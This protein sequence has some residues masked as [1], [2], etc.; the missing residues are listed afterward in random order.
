M[1]TA[2]GCKH[3]GEDAMG[4]IV[5]VQR[6]DCPFVD[7][8][9]SAVAAGAVAVII[10]NT[11][12]RDT[13]ML[14][15]DLGA[16]YL[17]IPVV[18]VGM[19]DGA[20]LLQGESV[21]NMSAY[22]AS[23]IRDNECF[24]S[25]AAGRC[26]DW[27]GYG[28]SDA[29]LT[30]FGVGPYEADELRLA[31]PEACNT[32][33]PH[34][35]RCSD[36]SDYTI[37][38]LSQGMLQDCAA[39]K[40]RKLCSQDA[41]RKMC[42]RTCGTCEIEVKCNA[43]NISPSD[44][45]FATQ[46]SASDIACFLKASFSHTSASCQDA[47]NAA[48]EQR[49]NGMFNTCADIKPAGMCDRAVSLCPVTCMACPPSGKVQLTIPS[50]IKEIPLQSD[51]IVREDV[52]LVIT[53][54]AQADMSRPIF[55]M[56]NFSIRVLHGGSLHLNEV[57]VS[58]YT[59]TQSAIVLGEE[60][61]AYR[62]PGNRLPDPTWA[63]NDPR[64]QNL[65]EADLQTLLETHSQPS[66]RYD[67]PLDRPRGIFQNCAFKNM[68]KKSIRHTLLASN[69][70]SGLGFFTPDQVQLFSNSWSW[71][72]RGHYKQ[73][74]RN[75]NC[76]RVPILYVLCFAIWWCNILQCRLAQSIHSIS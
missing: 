16:A 40:R 19:T 67:F 27:K 31:C 53:G 17:E 60:S 66:A 57:V 13:A 39:A 12:D 18:T 20:A 68:Q 46:A 47:A 64:K 23:C 26:I 38:V 59:G 14:Y 45:R 32:Q 44:L 71:Q 76:R 25:P 24:H 50:H 21:V 58:E 1:N 65:S 70:Q 37:E 8:A 41:L 54:T 34:C 72:R 43:D 28:C 29:M 49:T 3:S 74:K 56:G 36:E 51:L 4:K 5:V 10:V 73:G 61:T 75:C 35:Q 52:E 7:K 30:A 63:P 48:V 15:A 55:I 9:A 22:H 69:S 33:A 42:P 62:L 2:T 11:K 6:G